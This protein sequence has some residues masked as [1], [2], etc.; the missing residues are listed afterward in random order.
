MAFTT[1]VLLALLSAAPSQSAPSATVMAGGH[2]YQLFCAQE[3][4]LLVASETGL[5]EKNET[6]GVQHFEVR[7]E[8]GEVQFSQDA[9]QG[10]PFTYVAIFGVANAGREVLDVDTAQDG[11][12][13]VSSKTTHLIYYFD[14]GPSHLIPFDP[15]MV[16]VDGFA[17][18]DKGLALSRTFDTGYFQFS[19]LLGFNMG[20]HRIEI[21]PDQSVFSALPPPG[22]QKS[23]PVAGSGELKLYSNHNLT[24]VKT[25]VQIKPGH[26]IDW[27][28][29]PGLGGKAGA[30]QVVTILSAWAPASLKPADNAPEGVKMVYFDWN[31]LWLQIEVD[32]HMGWIK[33]SASF[34][35]I[36]LQM[37]AA[38]SGAGK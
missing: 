11:N 34:R 28:Q 17:H 23:G 20:T 7:N 38:A 13:A 30:S 10:Q 5:C 31:N 19:L 32:D 35:M 29:S 8:D 22:R 6:G 33:G 15:P 18:V 12:P 21:M 16:G 27:W 37:A 3:S 14:P 2:T 1:L 9:P 26:A 24:A 4:E 25:P 36:G